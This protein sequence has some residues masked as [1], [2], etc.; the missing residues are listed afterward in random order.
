MRI[1]IV[2]LIITGCLNGEVI[3]QACVT[4]LYVFKSK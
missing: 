2:I 4:M 3:A 1:N